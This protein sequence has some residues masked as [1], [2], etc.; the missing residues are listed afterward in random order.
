MDYIWNIYIYI[1]VY[2]YICVFVYIYIYIICIYIY[3]YLHYITINIHLCLKSPI[4]TMKYMGFHMDFPLPPLISAFLWISFFGVVYVHIQMQA[5]RGKQ[6]E[7]P[8]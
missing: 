7:S 6:V 4:N 3:I 5:F 1:Y 2:I 8:V